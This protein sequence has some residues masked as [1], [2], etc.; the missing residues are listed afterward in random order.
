MAYINGNEVL[1]SAAVTPVANNID[2]VQGTGDSAEAVMSQKAVTAEL[3]KI[4]AKVANLESVARGVAFE[5]ETDDS[6]GY[7][8]FVPTKAAPF[9]M[10]DRVGSASVRKL[11]GETWELTENKPTAL[12]AMS[13]NLL[14]FSQ[15][16]WFVKQADGTWLCE[17][18]NYPNTTII[19]P[20]N[21]PVGTYTLTSTFK[22]NTGLN[23]RVRVYCADGTNQDTYI[24]SNGDW[25][26]KSITVEN[27]AIIG[28]GLYYSDQGLNTQR[29]FK[30][31]QLERGETATEYVPYGEISTTPITDL[32]DLDGWG[33]G[34]P[35]VGGNYI[36]FTD[37]GRVLYQR[38]TERI[39][40]SGQE[41]WHTSQATD[42]VTSLGNRFYVQLTQL[43]QFINAAILVPSLCNAY[44]TL[45]GNETYKGIEG[46]SVERDSARFYNPAYAYG[47][48]D[49]W[50]AYVAAR[51]AEGNPI[52]IE[53]ALAELPAP[54]DV[55]ARFTG[56]GII[57]VE[58]NGYIVADN[59]NGEALPSAVTY[60][61]SLR[62]A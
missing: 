43:S 34:V 14:D 56:S 29:W 4:G 19:L 49:E 54:I 38:T 20:L 16:P 9:A 30:N 58:P 37:D 6:V 24:S 32:S 41:R 48:V 27:K 13:K 50:K 23:Y 7:Q 3:C 35:S 21:L 11:V 47:T 44:E 1:F 45:T 52:I 17:G 22:G 18:S 31:V 10:L 62:E 57:S 12:R 59:A 40:L 26:T 55:T 5:F 39:V 46:V 61:V 8:K 60:Q 28:W 15:Q 51:Y 42:G 36:E 33:Q 25:L 53:Y 2:V